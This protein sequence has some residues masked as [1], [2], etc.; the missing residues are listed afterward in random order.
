V[1]FNQ[2]MPA[3]SFVIAFYL[4]ARALTAIRLIGANPV[5]GADAPSQQVMR[6][7]IE[8][9]ALLIPSLDQWT[10]S[11]WLVDRAAAWPTV[12]VLGAQSALFLT[13]LAAAAVFDL[14]R[15]NF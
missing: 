15:R 1:T 3:A 6:W 8:G 5:G 12:G 11:T 2:L 13:I 14:Q 4:F 10:Q 9:L 7:L